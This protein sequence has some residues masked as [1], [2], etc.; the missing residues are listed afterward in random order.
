MTLAKSL[1]GES[2]ISMAMSEDPVLIE[3]KLMK[4]DAQFN[5]KWKFFYFE[6]VFK[7]VSHDSLSMNFVF[8]VI[9]ALTIAITVLYPLMS[10]NI[11]LEEINED[12]VFPGSSLLVYLTPVVIPR[13][14]VLAIVLVFFAFFLT[15]F[16]VCFV[17]PQHILTFRFLFYPQI[18]L[19]FYPLVTAVF[20][21]SIYYIN[22]G[23]YD[24]KV[25][26][27]FSIII[28]ILFFFYTYT[29][30]LL[31][32]IETNSIIKP[33]PL[34]SEWFYGVSVF[35]PVIIA[36]FSLIN[37]HGTKFAK[38]PEIAFFSV[39]ALVFILL[40]VFTCICQPLMMP[41]MNEIFAAKFFVIAVGSIL[42][43]FTIS[44]GKKV[45]SFISVILLFSVLVFTILH[46]FT[47]LAKKAFNKMINQIGDPDTL[48]IDSLETTFESIFQERKFRNMIKS[49]LLAG[50][51]IV[52]DET[53]V[54]FCLERYPSSEWMLKYVVFLYATIWGCDS[55]TYQF[56]LH[57]CSVDLLSKTSEAILFE[58]I[59]CYMQASQKISPMILRDLENY[60]TTFLYT[61]HAHR[62]FWSTNA[63]HHS[64]DINKNQLLSLFYKMQK[65][66]SRMCQCYRFCPSVHFERAI[67]ESDFKHKYDKSSKFFENGV[68]LSRNPKYFISSRL[69]EPFKFYFPIIRT[70]KMELTSP[71]FAKIQIGDKIINQTIGTNGSIIAMENNINMQNTDHSSDGYSFI[72]IRDQND[73]ARFFSAPLI[74]YDPYIKKLCKPF[75]ISKTQLQTEYPFFNSRI[76]FLKVVLGFI[77]IS[78][79]TCMICHYYCSKYFSDQ[80]GVYHVILEEINA[81]LVFRR[82]IS[83]YQFNLMLLVD[84][85]NQTYYN[86]TT[87]LG[88]SNEQLSEENWTGFYNYSLDHIEATERRILQFRN[89]YDRF[90]STFPGDVARLSNLTYL[91]SQVHMIYNVLVKSNSY[92]DSFIETIEPTI[93]TVIPELV[94]LSSDIYFVMINYLENHVQNVFKGRNDLLITCIV[95]EIFTPIFAYIVIQSS[96]NFIFNK[97][98]SIIRTIQ[99]PVLKYIANMFEKP[100]SVEEHQEIDKNSVSTKNPGICLISAFIICLIYP[101][102]VLIFVNVKDKTVI[103]K[104]ELPT[105][106][107]L[108]I[109]SK[110]VFYS[111]AWLEYQL[112]VPSSTF[113]LETNRTIIESIFGNE[114]LCINRAFNN[115]D[116]DFDVRCLFFEYPDFLFRMISILV[117][118]VS[119]PILCYFFHLLFII[120]KISKTGRY[121]LYF[122]PSL[123]VN[124]NPVFQ[125]LV[126]GY[127]L[128]LKDVN[129]FAK[130]LKAVPKFKG[131]FCTFFYDEND[132]IIETVG[133][134]Q[135]FMNIKPKNLKQVSEYFE[136]ATTPP[137]PT[138]KTFFE[139]KGSILRMTIDNDKDISISFVNDDQLFIKSEISNEEIIKKEK[140]LK[141]LSETLEGFYPKKRPPIQNGILFAITNLD[142]NYQKNLIKIAQEQSEFFIFDTRNKSIFAAIDVNQSTNIKASA[143]ICLKYLNHLSKKE[144]NSNNTSKIKAAI[145]CGGPMTFFD[146]PRGQFSKSRCVSKCY[147]D[148]FLLTSISEPGHIYITKEFLDQC[149]YKTGGIK[150]FEI[151]TSDNGLLKFYKFNFDKISDIIKHNEKIEVTPDNE[152]N[153]VEQENESAVN[154]N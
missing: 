138:I 98:F 74:T 54:R 11:Q 66:I 63:D 113:S 119:A 17:Y 132:E 129:G 9:E 118:I 81:T 42:S 13:D 23:V 154:N 143:L 3:S 130:E 34:F 126:R 76:R 148:V 108:S 49:G 149:Q 15:V 78:Y 121:I 59:Y 127:H 73:R 83:T 116:D 60:R 50:N 88:N 55:D 14:Y 94:E 1:L 65:H 109:P 38:T 21:Y 56:F 122:L 100:L 153:K 139:T 30:C 151:P 136:K 36:F 110:F 106:R 16:V 6:S 112:N 62:N 26:F 105:V 44:T 47:F 133:D 145:T 87:F 31:C 72:S 29:L 152:H 120:E 12:S 64:F 7:S 51:T 135:M 142:E 93:M 70:D 84:I 5:F 45:P 52:I 18:H 146:M 53:F 90:N 107:R 24:S 95:L 123:A 85:R 128:S 114:I 8:L 71:L 57:L 46:F 137:D 48:T 61:C 131:A 124:S 33:N 22:R 37:Y 97:V 35:Y 28:I 10:L 101:I 39:E 103:Y 86:L 89:I 2:K 111:Q 150:I 19:I 134:R 69:F 77:I 80:M 43:I 68:N 99:P 117:L 82:Q 25:P 96:V 41:V 75:Y 125:A 4:T 58:T 32:F 91:L 27:A 102:F 40:G 115:G 20:G 92:F 79:V 104:T 67:Y 147:D 141:Y 140:L 144:N